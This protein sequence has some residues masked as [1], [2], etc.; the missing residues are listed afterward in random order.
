MTSTRD[1]RGN[2]KFFLQLTRSAALPWYFHYYLAMSEPDIVTT[3]P[4]IP[5]ISTTIIRHH[6]PFPHP[7]PPPYHG[8][9]PPPPA[10]AVVGR[11]VPSQLSVGI[12]TLP[13]GRPSLHT[14]GR[15]RTTVMVQ[16]SPGEDPVTNQRSPPPPPPIP[17]G[18]GSRPSTPGW[19]TAKD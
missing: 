14:V 4:F 15:P 6:H 10:A 16:H 9:R 3:T 1:A 8:H 2:C 13:C 7:P 11:P 12:Q 5:I 19:P 18:T 17:G